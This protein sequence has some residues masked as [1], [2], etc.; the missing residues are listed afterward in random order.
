MELQELVGKYSGYFIVNY[1]SFEVIYTDGYE[2]ENGIWCYKISELHK[3]PEVPN[4]FKSLEQNVQET[5][6]NASAE[7]NTDNTQEAQENQE[8]QEQQEQQA[9]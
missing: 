7:E 3:K 9:Q 6:E 5:D 2:N 8:Q 1:D 4:G